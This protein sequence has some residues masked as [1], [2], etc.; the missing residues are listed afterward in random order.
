MPYF[1]YKCNACNE[2]V[3]NKL[4]KKHDEKVECPYCKAEMQKQVAATKYTLL[5]GEG[6]YKQHDKIPD[7]W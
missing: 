5:C 1:D 3:A 6:F 4:V 7:N 2:E